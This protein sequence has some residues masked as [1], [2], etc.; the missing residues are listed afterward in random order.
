M[1]RA[2]NRDS[3]QQRTERSSERRRTNSGDQNLQIKGEICNTR[4]IYM[5]A[6]KPRYPGL[7]SLIIKK[8]ESLEESKVKKNRQTSRQTKQIPLRKEKTQSS[9]TCPRQTL[10]GEKGEM[11]LLF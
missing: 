10:S 2:E 8:K 4:K 9:Q 7:K 6:I 3:I 5:S 1:Y 11:S